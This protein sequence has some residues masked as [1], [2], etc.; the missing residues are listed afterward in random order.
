[1]LYCSQIVTARASLGQELRKRTHSSPQDG[2][3]I[4]NVE[5][6]S[7]PPFDASENLVQGTSGLESTSPAAIAADSDAEKHP[8][9]NNK[10]QIVDKSVIE[11]GHG[12]ETKDQ[13]PQSASV[14]IINEEDE[15]DA[16]DWLNEESTETHNS[17]KTTIPIENEDDVSFSDLEDDDDDDVPTS[18]KKTSNSSD[19]DS[20]DWVQ[21]KKTSSNASNSINVE[22]VN[23]KN[24][25]SKE[26]NDWLDIDDI[27]VA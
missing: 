16:D 6:L 25:E 22:K 5:S 24:S 13:T 20:Q 23:A 14:N 10:V 11:E 27:E 2:N 17:T 26:S 15:D 18:Y 7:V 19:K 8:D 12:N 1:M 21:L 4:P 9:T 3:D